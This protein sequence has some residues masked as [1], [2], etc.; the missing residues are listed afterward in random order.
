MGGL[1]FESLSINGFTPP[2]PNHKAA[3]HLK[4]LTS[5]AGDGHAARE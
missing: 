5:E 4:K 3:S 1:G 2:P